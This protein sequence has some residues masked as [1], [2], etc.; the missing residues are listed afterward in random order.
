MMSAT[1]RLRGCHR[2]YRGSKS[3]VS[4]EEKSMG[5]L[6]GEWRIAGERESETMMAGEALLDWRCRWGPWDF[7]MT[8]SMGGR[9]VV[10]LVEVGGSLLTNLPRLQPRCHP[11][12]S[13]L[14][15]TTTQHQNYTQLGNRQTHSVPTPRN[16]SSRTFSQSVLVPQTPSSS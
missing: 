12:S 3:G 13:V 9:G 4:T 16:Q 5:G 2:S 8:P 6:E 10:S 14:Q 11:P 7:R 1:G 15:R